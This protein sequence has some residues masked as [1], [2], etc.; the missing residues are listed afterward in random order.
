MSFYTPVTAKRVQFTSREVTKSVTT[1]ATPSTKRPNATSITPRSAKITK[2]D[3]IGH[4]LTTATT[5][6]S[7][8]DSVS[9][10]YKTSDTTNLIKVGIRI[11][12]TN[13]KEIAAG[14]KNTIRVDKESNKIFLKDATSKQHEFKADYVITD[15]ESTTGYNI[16]NLKHVMLFFFELLTSSKTGATL[17]VMTKST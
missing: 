14:S 6:Q 17:V 4:V 3:Q 10:N 13:E 8:L 2:S 15:Q 12:P 1:T 11:R 16:I 9:S 5:N 7:S